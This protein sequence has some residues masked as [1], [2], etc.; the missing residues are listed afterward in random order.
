MIP[1]VTFGQSDAYATGGPTVQANPMRPAQP[2][3]LATGAQDSPIL[4]GANPQ[5]VPPPVVAQPKS[6]RPVAWWEADWAK[7][8]AA[9]KKSALKLA[10]TQADVGVGVAVHD[11][12]GT[13]YSD[14]V[15]PDLSQPSIQGHVHQ[16]QLSKRTGGPWWHRYITASWKG[17]P[18]VRLEGSTTTTR[19]PYVPR[20]V[21]DPTQVMPGFQALGKPTVERANVFPVV[22]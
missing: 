12:E 9:R 21:S 5:E 4:K 14:V 8:D 20:N 18:A 17:F 13:G 7:N 1:V 10:M 6:P 11:V 22:R 3:V 16:S 15:A 2:T 19:Q